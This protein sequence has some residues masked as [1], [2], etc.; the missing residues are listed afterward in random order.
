MH[1]LAPV[2]PPCR[3]RGRVCGRARAA[4][5]VVKACKTCNARTDR[6]QMQNQICQHARPMPDARASVPATAGR[7]QLMCSVGIWLARFTTAPVG[8]RCSYVV[9][10][11]KKHALGGNERRATRRTRP[12]WSSL[13]AT[14]WQMHTIAT[15]CTVVL[16]V[17]GIVVVCARMKQCCSRL[18]GW[19]T[20]RAWRRDSRR[21]RRTRRSK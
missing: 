15:V 21:R 7:G 13:T 16:W 14:L 10:S 1:T 19:R 5:R 20:R 17:M 11:S 12:R 9:A 3:V 2:L 18:L 4:C 8:A 6:C